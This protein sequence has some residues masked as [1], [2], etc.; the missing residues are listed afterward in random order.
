MVPHAGPAYSGP[1]AA[2]FY[3]Q[4][5]PSIERVI[6]LGVNHRADGHKAALSPWSDWETPLG[7]VAVDDQIGNFLA[8]QV[9]FLKRDALPHVEEHSIEIQ[10]PFLQHALRRFEFVPISLSHLSPGESAELGKAIAAA[11]RKDAGANRKTI[12]LASSDLSHYLSPSKT[13]ELDRLAL[14]QILALDP[15]RLL[16]IVEDEGI[17][18][19]GVFPAAVMLYAVN[20]LG[21]ARVHLLKHCHSGDVVPMRRVVGYASVAIEL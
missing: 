2:Y 17:S 16:R 4:L 21:V 20:A 7:R 3:A 19:C 8:D 11:C 5:D 15:I 18:M 6:V 12:V 10:L 14:E 9:D 13:Y 1:C